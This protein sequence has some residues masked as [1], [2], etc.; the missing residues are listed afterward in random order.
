[1]ACS[2][3]NRKRGKVG[4]NHLRVQRQA[5]D[6]SLV[7]PGFEVRVREAKEDFVQLATGEMVWQELHRVGAHASDVL[8]GHGLRFG[9][10]GSQRLDFRLDVF[11]DGCADLHAYMVGTVLVSFLSDD[12]VALDVV[13]PSNN[14]SGILG[15]RAKRRPPKP[16]P[17]SATSTLLVISRTELLSVD[18]AVSSFASSLL[19]DSLS[20]RA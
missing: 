5:Y 14:V 17:M 10:L 13:V 9:V 6:S 20:C 19:T 18:T 7:F 8:E 2:G 15:A 1:M 3:L 4:L 11:S 16:H 12:S